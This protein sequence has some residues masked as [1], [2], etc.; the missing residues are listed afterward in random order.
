[1]ARK[2]KRPPLTNE[3]LTKIICAAITAVSAVAAAFIV[4]MLKGG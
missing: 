4:A 1:M 2:R 3:Q